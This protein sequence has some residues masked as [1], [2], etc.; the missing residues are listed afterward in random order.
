VLYAVIFVKPATLA[1]AVIGSG[2]QFNQGESQLKKQ[3]Q[4]DK[5]RAAQRFRK[6]ADGSEEQIQF[7]L[8]LPEVLALVQQGLMN[9]ALAAF[10]KLVEE[11]MR[12]EVTGLVGPKNQANSKR[13]NSRW[14]TQAGYCVVGGQKVPLQRPRVRDVRQREVPLG[15]YEVL[16]QASLMEDSVWN[17][18]MHGLTTRRYSEVVRELEQAYGIEKS[19]V[20]EHF[21]EASRRR[22]E[23]LQARPLAEYAFC[24][25]LIDGTYFRDQ[26][27]VVA[28]GVTLQGQKVILGLHQGATENTTVVKHLLDD[29]AGRGVDFE[30]PRLY[31]LD[32]GKAL[33]AAVRKLAGKCALIQRCQ[34][35]KIRNVVDH[36]TEEYQMDIRCKMRNA[37]AM[38]EYADAKRALEALLRQLMHLNPSAARSLEE[39]MEETLT[40]HRLRLPARLRRTLSSTNLIE[41]AFSTVETVCRN[42]KRWQGGDQYLRWVASGLLWAESRWNRIHGHREL[43]ILVKELELA[44]VKTVPV[45]HASVA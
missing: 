30:V 28:I 19:T 20:S 22:L 33:Y 5:Q 37:Y 36:L 3:Y 34:V 9:L 14:G 13:K 41:S 1:G 16:Q 18:L 27:V 24:A 45:R 29:I 44:V 2:Q 8:P 21:I 38:Q 26:Q 17:K 7:A 31:I 11:M 43:P 42:V 15:S 6:E 40:M 10:T 25:M 39:G 12:W 4:I 23:K 35:H 32:G